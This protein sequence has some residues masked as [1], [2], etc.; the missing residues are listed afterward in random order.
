MTLANIFIIIFIAAMAYWWSIQGV[1]SSFLHLGVTIAAATIALAC[2]E[3][4][5]IGFLM[6]RMASYAWT[7]GLLGP[8]VLLLI[9]LS[10]L[11][12]KLVPMNLRFSQIPGL[13]GGAAFGI[14]SAILTSGLT[15]I[16]LG[17]LP[18]GPALGWYQPYV[19]GGNGQIQR[20]QH[21]W[22]NV[23]GIAYGFFSVLA[24]GSFAPWSGTSL[25]V[26]QPDLPQ[27]SA[28]VRLA[29][30]KDASVVAEPGAVRVADLF[31]AP[32]PLT[33]I[34]PAVAL[35]LGDAIKVTTNQIIVVDT[36]WTSAGTRATYDGD[37]TLRISPAQ[38]RLIT[39]PA[40]PGRMQV[41]LHAPLAVSKLLNQNTGRRFFF[42]FDSD[43]A[44]AHSEGNGKLGWVF[45]VP[46]DREPMSLLVRHLRLT[47]PQGAAV[48]REASKVAG[49]LGRTDLPGATDQGDDAAGRTDRPSRDGG[50]GDRQGIELTERLPR[51]FNKQ[52]AG[53][54]YDGTAIKEGTATVTKVSARG[55]TRTT[56]THILTPSHQASVR[57]EIAQDHARLVF[58][59]GMESAKRLAGIWL[60]DNQ[61]IEYK[62]IAY[63]WTDS[64]NN[65]KK[66]SVPG[67]EFRSAKELPISEM[68]D[69]D[70]LY[71]Y[72]RVRR[73][74]TIVSYHIG[75]TT[76][77]E[78][79]LRIP[80]AR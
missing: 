37:L 32:T 20:N 43:D 45:I 75:N 58:G 55:G 54:E 56:V 69:G 47:L 64:G 53:L 34:S 77:Q 35:G 41:Q 11:V 18:V 63:V 33:E 5:V 78:V 40:G 17:F 22:V 1:F 2:W 68:D 66:V 19:V 3:P 31:V 60:K 15:V 4:L 76:Q 30:D 44:M 8:F 71:L 38:I 52:A 12:D 46:S 74:R 49:V 73:N 39:R 14:I 48:E 80:P 42:P 23:D 36:Q 62:P 27:Q 24:G 70:K 50:V 10:V 16:A 7:V 65:A 25:G 61:G 28:L 79:N 6:G 57:I 67:R 26:Y 51:S 13:I 21:L 9:L 59:R 29:N 72:F